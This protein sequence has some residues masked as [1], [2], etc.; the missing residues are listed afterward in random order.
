[1]HASTRSIHPH[2]HASTRSM[3]VCGRNLRS[4]WP[5]PLRLRRCGGE[6]G[7]EQAQVGQRA[8]E[9]RRTGASRCM[10]LPCLPPCRRP[11]R[12]VLADLLHAFP[13]LPLPQSTKLS[14]LEERARS[15][16]RQLS[17]AACVDGGD[18]GDPHQRKTNHAGACNALS[19]S[20]QPCNSCSAV[21]TRG[22]RWA[23]RAL[24]A[25]SVCCQLYTGELQRH[26]VTNIACYR[27]RWEARGRAAWPHVRR[28]PA[29]PACCAC[30]RPSADTLPL[31]CSPPSP[32]PSQH[33]GALFGHMSAVNLLGRVLDM[34]DSI[35]SAPDNIGSLY[36]SVSVV[37]LHQQAAGGQGVERHP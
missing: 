27:L 2:M 1:M 31:P 37:F 35:T 17:P 7:D 11:A 6:G 21:L 34:P 25:P 10:S 30:S 5:S 16:G 12:T 28:R 23:S 3:Q 14:V 13:A 26:P 4:S 9:Q 20:F 36:K 32:L 22:L 29:A 18:G 19:G 15:L 33:V 24:L 8:P